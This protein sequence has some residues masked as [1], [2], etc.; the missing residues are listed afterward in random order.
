MERYAGYACSPIPHAAADLQIVHRFQVSRS[1]D[2]ANSHIKSS[3]EFTRRE[4][5]LK[6]NMLQY[7]VWPIPTIS[8]SGA[9]VVVALAVFAG[10]DM[11]DLDGSSK[12]QAWS[13]TMTTKVGIAF[14]TTHGGRS[15][16]RSFALGS[17]HRLGP[18]PRGTPV[19]AG[20]CGLHVMAERFPP[21][22]TGRR[23]GGPRRRRGRQRHGH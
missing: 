7:L 6:Y 19:T 3:V 11:L 9:L 21:H 13:A 5:E 16:D 12:I 8:F 15:R 14:N 23:D 22:G 2:Q 18:G 1:I 4:I 20:P 17:L 10:G